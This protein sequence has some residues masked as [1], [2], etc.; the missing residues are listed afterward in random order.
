MSKLII[1]LAGLFLAPTPAV[2]AQTPTKP[3]SPRDSVFCL[4]DTNLISV[5]Y[6]RPS[7]RGRKIMGELVPYGVVWRTG[8]N[9][10]TH[11]RT[12]LDMLLGGVPVPRGTYTLW[13]LPSP[14][15]WK[16]ILNKQTG[17]WGTAYDERQ[18]YARFDAIV[19]HLE[20]PVETL[21]IAFDAT[22]KTHGRLKLMWEHTLVWTRF[23]K[24]DD[25]R[26]VSPLDSA[27]IV[28]N[29]AAVKVKYSRPFMRGRTMWGV[30]VPF[31]TIWRTGANLATELHTSAT[32]Y[33][34]GVAVP[35]GVYTIYS[36][37]SSSGCT[38]I[39][40]KKGPGFPE[41]DPQLD[42]AHIA[43]TMKSVKAP[44]D[45]FTISFEPTSD[46]SLTYL[47][48][49]WADREFLVDVRVK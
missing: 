24:R 17:Q 18:D 29:N 31:D 39:I 15:G 32:T 5:N 14:T 13:T 4:I 1:G 43:L 38:L 19:E 25:I 47:K 42:L 44:I 10:A 21:T 9:E 35:A 20:A 49:G 30:I 41:Y 2:E 40:N 36:K 45:P 6:G 46:K 22:G 12:N 23:E 48:L 26:P 7:M 34:G 33:L 11:L 37:P 3:L 16:F 8:A 27:E 28:L